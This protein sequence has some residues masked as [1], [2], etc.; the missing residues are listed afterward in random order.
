MALDRIPVIGPLANK[1]HNADRFPVIGR[2]AQLLRGLKNTGRKAINRD[3]EHP[4]SNFSP[5]AY[6][7]LY[8]DNLASADLPDKLTSADGFDQWQNSKIKGMSDFGS[9]TLADGKTITSKLGKNKAGTEVITTA[10][11]NATALEPNTT[12]AKEKFNERIAAMNLQ[13]KQEPGKFN[14]VDYAEYLHKLKSKAKTAVD[15]QNKQDKDRVTKLFNQPDFTKNLKT[16]LGLS[17]DAQL[18]NVQKQMLEHLEKKQAESSTQF[19]EKLNTEI[20]LFHE[21]EQNERDRIAYLANMDELSDA[22]KAEINRL[23]QLNAKES[24]VSIQIGGANTSARFKG[25]SVRDMQVIEDMTGE[26]IDHDK[27]EKGND[28]FSMKLPRKFF[29]PLYSTRIQDYHLRGIVNAVRACGYNK[30]TIEINYHGRDTPHDQDDEYAMELGRRAYE[31]CLKGGFDYKETL[32]PNDKDKKNKLC[33]IIINVNGKPK[34]AN[35]LFAK[36]QQRK[37]EIHAKADADQ[38]KRKAYRD[39]QKSPPEVQAVFKKSIKTIVTTTKE[40]KKAEEALAAASNPLDS[41]HAPG[42]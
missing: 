17:D 3:I 36:C 16:A 21:K 24:A 22:M 1:L 27:D 31:Q 4:L 20:T 42:A 35:E 13:M 12:T 32:D 37:S 26:K 38:A 10:I 28:R 2:A 25:I 30:I 18:E 7:K 40:K 23:G 41:T 9:I 8:Q 11:A 29:S 39:N 19:E 15:A 6:E 5:E 14:F 34:T 33:N